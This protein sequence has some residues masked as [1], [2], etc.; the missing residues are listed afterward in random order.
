M[1]PVY[2]TYKPSMPML[3]MPKSQVLKDKVTVLGADDLAGVLASLAAINF[4]PG[5]VHG[6]Y[7]TRAWSV[8]LWDLSVMPVC[9]CVPSIMQL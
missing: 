6:L 4:H 1:R 8:W 7:L 2:T 9:T 5:A 3:P